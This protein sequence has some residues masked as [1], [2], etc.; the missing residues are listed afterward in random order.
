MGKGMKTMRCAVF[1]LF[2]DFNKGASGWKGLIS[3]SEGL[4]NLYPKL[5]SLKVSIDD[6]LGT[7]DG[8][9]L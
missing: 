6:N 7:L 2:E 4:N 8:L 3:F 9:T 5:D 1:L